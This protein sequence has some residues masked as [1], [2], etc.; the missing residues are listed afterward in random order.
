MGYIKCYQLDTAQA[1]EQCTYL[2][3]SGESCKYH[4]DARGSRWARGMRCS[5]PLGAHRAGISEKVTCEL[6]K[7]KEG[8]EG[9]SSQREWSEQGETEKCS[10]KKAWPTVRQIW[11]PVPAVSRRVTLADQ[12]TYTLLPSSQKWG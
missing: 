7:E 8:E 10:G 2:F 12:H 5:F 6:L 1:K 3:P 9:H 4:G 11:V